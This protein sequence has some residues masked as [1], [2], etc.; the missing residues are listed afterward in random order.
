MTLERVKVV[1][2]SPTQDTLD[3]LLDDEAAVFWVDWREEEESIVQACEA[4][5]QTGSLVVK[6][7]NIDKDEGYEVYIQYLDRLLKIPLTYSMNDRHIAI[8]TL[9]DALRPDYEVRFC[10]ESNGS[11]TL[12]FIPLSINDWLELEKEYGDAVNKHFY[13]ITA[14]PNLFTD[15]LSF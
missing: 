3:A 6:Q 2:E 13:K 7:V 1:L 5:L 8:C 4:V 14:R 10:I 9:N 12:A 11:D 15:S